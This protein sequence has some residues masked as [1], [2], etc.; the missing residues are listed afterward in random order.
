MYSNT[1][2]MMKA[3]EKVF[4]IAMDLMKDWTTEERL[5]YWEWTTS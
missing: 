5:A 4:K 1:E 3:D 2:Y